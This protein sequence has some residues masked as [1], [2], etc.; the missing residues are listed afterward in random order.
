MKTRL[1]CAVA[2][3]LLCLIG[4]PDRVWGQAQEA[5]LVDSATNV[6]NEF[7]AIPAEGI[8]RTMLAKAQGLV[9]VPSMVKVGFVVGARRG[10]GIAVVR[11]QSGTWRPPIFVSVTGGSVGWQAGVQSSDIVMVFNSRRSVDGLLSGKFTVGVDAAAAAGPVGRAASAGTDIK[12]QAEVYSYSRSR[13]LFA[14]ASV[15]G[16]MLQIDN[17]ANQTYYSAAG[18][19]P[20]GTATAPNM[21][22]P[23]SAGRLLAALATIAGPP[24][25]PPVDPSVAGTPGVFPP[26]ANDVV[27]QPTFGAGQPSGPGMEPAAIANANA[28][29]PAVTQP[30]L[31]VPVPPAVPASS[32]IEAINATR[33]ELADAAQD[34]GA[35]LDE[36]WRNY[37]ALPRNALSGNGMPTVESLDQSL[38]R[39]EAIT[40]DNRYKVLL[41]RPEFQQLYGLLRTYAEQVRQATQPAGAPPSADAGAPGSLR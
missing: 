35:L 25:V 36:S 27:P 6:L 30:G 13:G 33:Q 38:S 12:L 5:A 29:I 32:G 22:L 39:F 21:P 31:S 3:L 41:D 4:A 23:T 16:T 24:T 11:D 9:I 40:K 15:D 20:D 18:L 26:A 10:K 1:A 7:M 17:A 14:G 19:R 8:P 37:L 34:L 28:G 2:A